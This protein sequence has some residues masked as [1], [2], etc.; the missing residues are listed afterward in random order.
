M[1][2][3]TGEER[4][5]LNLI[6]KSLDDMISEDNIVRVIDALV[7][8]F[9]MNAMKFTHAVPKA[10][11]RKPYDPRDLLKL[12][13]YG[14]YYSIRTSRKLERE[15]HRNIELMWLINNLK[16]DFKTIADFRKDN[17][18]ALIR[19]FKQFRLICDELNLIGKEVLAVDGSKFKANNSRRRNLTKRKVQ[20]ILVHY[21]TLARQYLDSLDQEESETLPKALSQDELLQKLNEINHKIAE[22][23][24]IAAEIERTGEISLT[25][26]DSK[27]MSVSN[28]GTDISHNVQIVVDKENHLVTTID[29]ISSPADQGQLYSMVEK[30]VDDLEIK[31][32]SEDEYKVTVLADKGYYVYDDLVKC[33]ENKIKAIVPKQ[34]SPSTTGYQEYSKDY[35][36]YDSEKNCYYCPQ[37]QKLS[38][39]SKST[40][41]DKKYRNFSACQKCESK[42]KCTKKERGRTILRSSKQVVYDEFDQHLKT[43]KELYKERQM[44]VEHPFGTVKRALGYTYFLTC[45]NAKVKAESALH[46]LIYNLKR[47]INILGFKNLMSYLMAHFCVNYKYIVFYRTLSL[48]T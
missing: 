39:I 21:E 29:V 6:P 13:I 38:C 41:K 25:D 11:G 18:P 28:N 43:N 37:G 40:T 33:K 10:T 35:F 8:T 36:T 26:P 15:S 16:P 22:Y 12:Y 32:S 30:A 3:I 44:I 31:V 24:L 9:D 23:E 19:S 1:R 45:G 14:Y 2:Y 42:S 47:V 5:Q 17:G 48:R 34:K 4:T 20:K 27:H 46:F 7:D